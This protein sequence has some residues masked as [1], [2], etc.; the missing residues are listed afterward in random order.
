VRRS[1]PSAVAS[2]VGLAVAAVAEA[3][4]AAGMTGS[5]A[6]GLGAR[7]Q[8]VAG[9]EKRETEVSEVRWGVAAAVVGR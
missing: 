2:A 9:P 1:Y 4:A 7:A 6:V 3:A 5:A 8:V